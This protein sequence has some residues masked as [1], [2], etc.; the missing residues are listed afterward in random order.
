VGKPSE[1]L[2]THCGSLQGLKTPESPIIGR[3]QHFC[4]FYLQELF[5]ALTVNTEEKSHASNRQRKRR[6]ILK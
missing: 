3:P 4:E 1:L 2:E 5:Q 6:T